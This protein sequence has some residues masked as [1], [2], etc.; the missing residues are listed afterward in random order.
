[1]AEMRYLR[2]SLWKT[3]GERENKICS[4]EKGFRQEIVTNIIE[5]IGMVWT[6]S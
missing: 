3:R 4:N 6:Y 2:E 5:K 1:M